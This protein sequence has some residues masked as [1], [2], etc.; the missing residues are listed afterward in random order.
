MHE[1]LVLGL[2]NEI[3]GDDA[4]GVLALRELQKMYAEKVDFVESAES[5]LR[6]L[7]YLLGYRKVLVL[8]SMANDKESPGVIEEIDIINY[9]ESYSPKSPH[10]V[11]LPYTLKLAKNLNLDLP[12][13]IKVVALHVL[14]PYTLQQDL[15]PPVKKALPFFIAFA[16]A[17]IEK[18]LAPPSEDN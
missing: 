14:D 7:D 10:Y 17:I 13:S 9:K 16:S 15:T 12:E 6:L 8:D 2:G 3:L 5:G 4:A 1:I 11:G 18:W